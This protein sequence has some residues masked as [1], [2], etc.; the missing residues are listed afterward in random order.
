MLS[1]GIWGAT[2]YMGTPF[3]RALLNAHRRGLLHFVILYRPES[4]LER[5]PTAIEKRLIDL[6]NGDMTS[7]AEK[8]R[9][10]QVVMWVSSL[11][12]SIHTVLCLDSV[13]IVS[14]FLMKISLLE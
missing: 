10:L 4:N 14:S 3:S 8:V 12:Y 7:I 2:G 13:F 11:R 6:N 5:Y 9:D 1:V